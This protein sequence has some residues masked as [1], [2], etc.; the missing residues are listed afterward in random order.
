M[1]VKFRFVLFFWLIALVGNSYAGESLTLEQCL[2][3]AR[4]SSPVLIQSRTS[5]QQSQVGVTVNAL[6][7]IG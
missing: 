7:E 4:E 6:A 2:S 5:I 3:L 1:T